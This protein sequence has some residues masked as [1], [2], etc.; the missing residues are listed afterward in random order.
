ML[1]AASSKGV[2][3]FSGRIFRE[4]SPLQLVA[5]RVEGLFPQGIFQNPQ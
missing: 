5:L 3:D 4:Q 2:S 1:V